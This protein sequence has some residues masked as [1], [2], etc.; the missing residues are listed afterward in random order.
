MRLEFVDIFEKIWNAV[1]LDFR[2]TRTDSHT[3]IEEKADSRFSKFVNAT[4]NVI[5]IL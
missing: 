2:S 4:K 5:F 1:F 3:I